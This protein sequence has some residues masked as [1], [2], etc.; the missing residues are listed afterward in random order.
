MVDWLLK[1]IAHSIDFRQY[2]GIKGNSIT[3]YLIEFI[4][5]ILTAQDGPTQTAVLACYVD[6]QK[7]FNRQNHLILI[8]KLD[9]LG[10]PGWLLSI[11]I[12]FLQN[13][14]MSVKYNGCMSSEKSLPG[15][16]PQG[17][18]LALLLFLVFI[19]DI[20][21]DGQMNNVGEV[22]TC[23]KNIKN[24][25]EIH[26][27]FV[28]D[29]TLAEAVNLQ[30]DLVEKPEADRIH[31]SNFHDRTNHSFPVESS[32]VHNQLL[33][34]EHY[35]SINDMRINYEK[36]KLMLFN[37]CTSKDFNPEMTIAGKS[38]EVVDQTKL[39]GLVITNDL[40]WTANTTYL[41]KKAYK[42]FWILRRLKQLGATQAS[43]C[44]V[45]TKQIRCIL[46]LAVPAWN[47][48]LTCKEKVQIER[49]QKCAFH[50]I[51]GNLYISY[52]KSLEVL[53]LETLEDR[54]SSLSLNFALKVEKNPKFKP[55]FKL[56]PK[57]QK[58]RTKQPKY[59]PVKSS[60]ARLERS[61]IGYLTNL[62]NT[63]YNSDMRKQT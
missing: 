26:L 31:P 15:G 53:N 28:D 58:S 35:A 7:A 25:N 27:K 59:C 55:W 11:I 61:P 60:H 57:F 52:E 34:T 36:T 47:G 20:G 1:F 39:L 40:K 46:E 3:H 32:R 37:P 38:I 56:N 48:S 8:K 18:L 24:M 51:L 6:F 4:N 30:Q 14:S 19:N 54:R 44:E 23:R 12:S 5:F 41:V 43:L 16:S 63:Y 29:L 49:V 21:F 42:R 45:Y 33:K 9:A 10:V 2:G 17:T 50:L 62:L 13:R 22:L